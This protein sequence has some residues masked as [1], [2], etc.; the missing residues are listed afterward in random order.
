MSTEC[1][2]NRR[3]KRQLSPTSR[4]RSNELRRLWYQRNK[5][6]INDHRRFVY[7]SRKTRIHISNELPH[8]RKYQSLA[9]IMQRTFPITVSFPKYFPN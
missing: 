6:S 8:S 2:S 9:D 3:K 1:T 5:D 7:H 4:D